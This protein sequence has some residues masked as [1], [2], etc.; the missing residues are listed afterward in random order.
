MEEK[1][2]GKAIWVQPKQRQRRIQSFG[3]DDRS[4][5]PEPASPNRLEATQSGGNSRG[6]QPDAGEV[7]NATALEAAAAVATAAMATAAQ[8]EPLQHQSQQQWQ[9][10]QQPQFSETHAAHV[11]SPPQHGESVRFSVR[12]NSDMEEHSATVGPRNW[13]YQANG[14]LQAY[15]SQ[16]GSDVDT[17]ETTEEV[18]PG[19]TDPVS[20]EALA[21]QQTCKE[22]LEALGVVGA[23]DDDDYSLSEHEPIASVAATTLEPHME[24]DG[25]EDDDDYAVSDVAETPDALTREPPVE[26]ATTLDVVATNSLDDEVF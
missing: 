9:Q 12:T 26:Q 4:T 1:N 16:L 8:L 15:M 11:S 21:P 7:S 17:R 10:Q 24:Q 25:Q 22:D 19:M 14:T 23:D 6:C 5:S 13:Q 18:T 20:Q 2:V 3:L